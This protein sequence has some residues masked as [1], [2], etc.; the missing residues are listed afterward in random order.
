MDGHIGAT[1]GRAARRFTSF[2]GWREVS[3][4][5][6]VTAGHTAAVFIPDPVYDQEW[7][8]HDDRQVQTRLSRM[9]RKSINASS[10]GDND[11]AYGQKGL[12]PNGVTQWTAPRAWAGHG[13]RE[14][15]ATRENTDERDDFI[16]PAPAE[17]P[18]H[19]FS[20]KI[21]WYLVIIIGIAGLFSGLSSNIYLPSLSAI[22]Q[23]ISAPALQ[24]QVSSHAKTLSG[25]QS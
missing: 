6:Y 24:L 17:M 8:A 21:K 4:G 22:A 7:P 23:V 9:Q 14:E 18:F 12:W 25:S 13:V 15:S 11:N 3:R 20:K 2:E 19:V 1:S 5:I 10:A 16:P